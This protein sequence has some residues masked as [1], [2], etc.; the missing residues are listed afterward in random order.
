MSEALGLTHGGAVC[1][2]WHVLRSLGTQAS[3]VRFGVKGLV[4]EFE[5]VCGGGRAGG[6]HRARSEGVV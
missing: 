4:Y 5:E 3:E 6:N 1:G 2:L